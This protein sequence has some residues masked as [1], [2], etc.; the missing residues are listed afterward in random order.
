MSVQL[1][2]LEEMVLL[3]VLVMQD[4]EAYGVSVAEE[5][6]KS[7]GKSISIPAIHT[8]LKRLQAKKL[9]E[10]RMGEATSV[11]GGKKKRLYSITTH[12][13]EVLKQI[14][15]QREQLWSLVP[16]LKAN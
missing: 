10:S 16:E 3:L 11:R 7:T 9:V 13:Y 1:G 4:T 14:Q 6:E 5:Y 2:N 8:V 12:G 15:A